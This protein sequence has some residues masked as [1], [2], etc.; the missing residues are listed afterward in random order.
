[1]PTLLFRAKKTGEC[2]VPTLLFRSKKKGECPVPT[3]LFRSQKKKRRVPGETTK[4]AAV[5]AADVTADAGPRLCP[6]ED[7]ALDDAPPKV[8]LAICSVGHK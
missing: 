5:R 4:R 2:P 1:M 6:S 8:V 3:L 7:R